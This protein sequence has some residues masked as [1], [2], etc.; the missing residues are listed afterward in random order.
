MQWWSV[1]W[2]QDEIDG[3][4]VVVK[5]VSCCSY[6]TS[7][8][9]PA[10]YYGMGHTVVRSNILRLPMSVFNHEM[11]GMSYVQTIRTPL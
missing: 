7:C 9:C 6:K 3:I 5:V 11:F 8:D 4:T 2:A 10:D 1:G